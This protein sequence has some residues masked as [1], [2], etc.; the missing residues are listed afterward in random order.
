MTAIDHFPKQLAAAKPRDFLGFYLPAFYLLTSFCV[1]I[2]FW[3]LSEYPPG[4]EPKSPSNADSPFICAWYLF[5][6]H[7]FLWIPAGIVLLFIH[8]RRDRTK[9]G[10]FYDK[11]IH[12][13]SLILLLIVCLVA[14]FTSFPENSSFLIIGI[15]LLLNGIPCLVIYGIG[16]LILA[17]SKKPSQE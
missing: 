11:E 8:L 17:I 4:E 16:R 15:S 5:A 6:L 7:P 12:L 13:L 10:P 14:S 9:S 3:C 2:V 1:I